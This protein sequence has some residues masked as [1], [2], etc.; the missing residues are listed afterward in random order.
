MAVESPV[1]DQKAQIDEY[2]HAAT[3]LVDDAKSRLLRL[4]VFGARAQLETANE[5][6]QEALRLQ[7][8]S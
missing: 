5:L 1:L 8:R 7:S 2:V 4:D 6:I 3:V